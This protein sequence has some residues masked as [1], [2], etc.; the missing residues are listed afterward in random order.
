[1]FKY[2]ICS[3]LKTFIF[4]FSDLKKVKLKF[5]SNFRKVKNKKEI[6][7]TG[8][9]IKQKKKTRLVLVVGWPN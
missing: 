9:K 5:C 6:K 2:E 1:M 4:K 7:E 3:N 8:K